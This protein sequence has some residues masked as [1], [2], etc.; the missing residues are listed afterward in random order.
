MLR[1]DSFFFRLKAAFLPPKGGSYQL[2]ALRR[3]Q[4]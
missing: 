2:K 4:A 3:R 1:R